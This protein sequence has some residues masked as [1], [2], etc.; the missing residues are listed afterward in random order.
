M[1]ACINLPPTLAA[2]LSALFA[3]K[4]FPGGGAPSPRPQGGCDVLGA[5]IG[6]C[7]PRLVVPATPVVVPLSEDRSR[8]ADGGSFI[9]KMIC[10]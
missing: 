10:E 3:A 5:R 8:S 4:S 6:V 2:S 1:S 9:L 7:P